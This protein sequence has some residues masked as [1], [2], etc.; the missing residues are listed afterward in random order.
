MR[1]LTYPGHMCAPCA[2]GAAQ[3]ACTEIL[4]IYIP[5]GDTSLPYH[6]APSP[7]YRNT[8]VPG[9]NDGYRW[10]LRELCILG[11]RNMNLRAGKMDQWLGALGVVEGD[12]S[13]IPDIHIAANNHLKL[14]SQKISFHLW[15]SWALYSYSHSEFPTFLMLRL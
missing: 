14:Q 2:I 10:L 7:Q 5:V 15:P 3:P 13:S 1:N 9:R 11:Q 4:N 6:S 8:K 12:P